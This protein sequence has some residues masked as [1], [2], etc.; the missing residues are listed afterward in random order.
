MSL[1]SLLTDILFVGHSLVGPHLPALV[2]GA[3]IRQG[4]RAAV[5]EAHVINGA[6]LRYNWENA[7]EAEG[8]NARIRLADGVD[9]LILTEAVPLAEQIT[10]NDTVGQIVAFGGLARAANPD[11]RIYLYET[12]HSLKSGP[13]TVIDGDAGAGVPWRERIDAD[14]A[15]WRDLAAAASARLGGAPVQIIPAGQAMGRLSDAIDA[16]A[17]PGFDDITQFFADDMHPNGKG[18][19]FL[20]LVHAA[21]IDGKDPKGLPPLLTRTWQD[22]D[23]VISDGLARALQRVAQDAVQA[24]PVIAAAPA[25][26]TPDLIAEETLVAPPDAALPA[27]L[28]P[29]TNPALSFG[30]AGVNDWSVQQPFLDVMK[31]A[32]VWTGH[33]PDQWGGFEYDQLVAEGF[34]D[35]QGWPLAIPPG[36]TGLST[37]ILTQLPAD[38]V[39]VAGDYVLTYQGT[40]TLVAEGRATDVQAS[41]GRIT[42]AYTPGEGSVV[43]TL[44]ATDAADPVRNIRLVRADRADLLASGAIFNPDWLARLR[45]VQGLRFM[46]WMATNN[47]TLSALA[48]RPEPDDATYARNGVPIEVMVALANELDADPWF[49]IP[50]LADDALVR[51][52]ATT[53]RDTLAPDLRASVE[54]SNEVWNWQFTQATWAEEQGQARWGQKDTWVQF[55]AFRAAQVADIWAQ[56]YGDQAATRLR[57][58]IATQTGWYGLEDQ[59]L[60]APLVIA[61]GGAAPATHFDAYA[62]TGYFSALLGSD[63][64]RPAVQDWLAQSRAADPERPYAL[65]VT[66]A[67]TELRDGSVTGDPADS[68]KQVLTELLPYHAKVAADHDLTLVMYEGGTHVVGYGALVDDAD[69]TAFFNHLNY[70]PE[71]A[72]LYGTLMTGWAGLSDAPFNA[73]VDVSAPDKWGSWG[74]LRHLGDENPRWRALAAG[75]GAC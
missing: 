28:T 48:D 18:L 61:E 13:D 39:G 12:W 37:L 31:T 55:Y 73:F 74:A 16:G 59:I 22:R 1:F 58:V 35:A 68:L 70:S 45:G 62:V 25:P 57:R 71:M 56:V 32:R 6:S 9:V 69:L 27:T 14:A 3:L 51:H 52:Y 24:A 53:V 26:D 21:M 5:V 2:E 67:T 64:K 60:N 75:C 42:F 43:L 44:T 10:W 20:A 72:A 40:G 19:Y 41:P 66:L 34:I 8:V 46:D 65:A 33:L 38:A 7:D 29:I 50:H 23:S 17:V 15:V 63:A 47:A 49:T 54:F 30:L 36:V 11:T 4:D